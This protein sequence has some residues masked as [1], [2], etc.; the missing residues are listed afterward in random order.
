[1]AIETVTKLVSVL[2]QCGLLERP[3]FEEVRRLQPKYQDPRALARELL[4][5]GWI[6]TFHVNQ[7][8]QGRA[9]ELVLGGYVLLE[10]IGE[11]G[12]GEVF[13]ARHQKLNRIVAL[14]IVRKEWLSQ[15]EAVRRF[16]R[17]IRAAAQ[18]THPNIVMSFDADHIGDTHFIAMEYVEGIDL[19]KLV[20]QSGAVP[21][22]LACDYVR[23]AA[24]GLQHA[25]EKGMVHRD[26]KPSNLLLTR[27]STGG[28]D[29]GTQG[30]WG[31]IKILD[32][33]LARIPRPAE[34]DRGGTLT[35][36]GAVVG[37]PDYISPEQ[38]RDSRSVDIRADLYSLGCTLYHL[39]AGQTP[40]PGGT[41]MEK[42]FKHQLD[43]PTP[44]QQL[45]PTLSPGLVRVVE[46]L[47]AKRAEDRFQTPAEAAKALEPFAQ[48]DA[49]PVTPPPRKKKKSDVGLR[50]LVADATQAYPPERA[51]QALRPTRATHD[52][53]T[54]PNAR[55]LKA[56]VAAPMPQAPRRRSRLVWLIAPAAAGFVLMV[57]GALFALLGRSEPRPTDPVVVA[58]QPKG[59][60]RDP[61]GVVKTR[62]PL[63]QLS[64]DK[65]VPRELLRE[66]PAEVVGVIGEHRL[67][68]WGN[69]SAL[70]FSPDGKRVASASAV[71]KSIRIWDA[72][73]GEQL[74]IISVPAGYIFSLAFTPD[75]K[76][77][78]GTAP[79]HPVRAWALPNGEARPNIESPVPDSTVVALSPDSRTMIVATKEGMKAVDV[80]TG[81][82]RH[83]LP[84][85]GST[86]NFSADSKTV[87]IWNRANRD[88]DVVLWDLVNG[89]QR[90]RLPIP[91]DLAP[92]ANVASSNDGQT[93]ALL[94]YKAI[95]GW[96]AAKGE[97]LFAQEL[98][99]GMT[100]LA[101][102]MDGQT[103]VVSTRQYIQLLNPTNGQER[104]RLARDLGQVMAGTVSSD[105]K[106][107]A[108]AGYGPGITVIDLVTGQ[109]RF[110]SSAAGHTI[111]SLTFSPD[112]TALIGQSGVMDS[113]T[114]IFDP[115]K[116]T[117]RHSLSL[118]GSPNWLVG[119]TPDGKFVVT[120]NNDGVY[121]WEA[122][123]GKKLD[124]TIAAS[125]NHGATV[126]LS[127]SGKTL[128]VS[129]H[130]TGVRLYDVP[131]FKERVILKN[132]ELVSYLAAAFT[133]DD[134]TLVTADVR[135]KIHVWNT[136]TGEPR[137]PPIQTGGSYVSSL[138]M[139]PDGKFAST[140]L[141]E[142]F[143]RVWDVTT[144]KEAVSVPEPLERNEYWTVRY[145]PDGRF[146][147]GVSSLRIKLWHAKNG[148]EAVAIKVHGERVGHVVFTPDGKTLVHAETD[149][150]LCF[151]DPAT[152]KETR[153]TIPMRGAVLGMTFAPDGRYLATSNANGT[154]YIF[155]LSA[156]RITAT[157]GLPSVRGPFHR[158]DAPAEERPDALRPE[159]PLIL[160]T[161]Q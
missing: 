111:Q 28:S 108:V 131:T 152:G 143:L 161:P 73:S 115:V 1:M 12:M 20:K 150:R 80:A 141:R 3:Q 137:I 135:G 122:T 114:R 121:L 68:H 103:L 4:Q 91:K 134:Q 22:P 156:D 157:L 60:D 78:I 17:E 5:R 158:P 84:P 16:D 36:A 99:G 38:A 113:L 41:G 95:Q 133:A 57:A 93:V 32:M 104:A 61:G 69:V 55:S 129:S 140:W 132:A 44:I 100:F 40:F 128:V 118:P 148:Q 149:G 21:V 48:A 18:L 125:R 70:A 14:K 110:A 117:E 123:T 43:M 138:S 7:L 119:M 75:G 35:H 2:D 92:L 155:R 23:Q 124:V 29:S 39:L 88:G 74:S 83:A 96:N 42:L 139:S 126:Y 13:K 65:I 97:K 49:G 145:S 130:T 127:P 82:E 76:S 153:P 56:P 26:I 102:G 66:L 109:E 112:G 58:T 25:H 46:K 85:G 151:Y 120:R 160:E 67:R 154:I 77:I 144:G 136:T 89:K 81:A 94:S 86:F 98:S 71:D 107:C 45:L 105:G 72:Q 62:S 15:P 47:M 52:D 59:T 19:G 63:D 27:S 79:N 51:P 159:K 9:R 8:F 11:G 34:E 53:L 31:Q 101:F 10:R 64:R 30:R 33:G 116:G 147:L 50:P 6:T 146:L 24:L 106:T 142:G 87:A 37:T 54:P 90:Y